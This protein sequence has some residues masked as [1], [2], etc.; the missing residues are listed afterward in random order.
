MF[1][2]IE[3]IEVAVRARMVQVYSEATGNSHWFSDYRLYKDLIRS[4][5]NGQT[6]SVFSRLMRE[7]ADEVARSNEDFIKH[8]AHK[9]SHP[10][11][12][13]AWMT[14]E[15]LS[16]GTLSKLYQLLKKSPEKKAI[17]KG[18]GLN[19]D[20]VMANWLH[21]IAVWRNCCAHHSR[22]WN[23]RSIINL[24]FPTNTDNPFIDR[25]TFHKAHANKLFVVLCCIKY[26]SNIISPK[27]DFKDN[28]LT[29][30]EK[31]G[32]L[33]NLQE[34]GFPADW[35]QFELWR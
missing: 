12:P 4:D 32:N 30:I 9:Y 31:G 21:A 10:A 1:N 15:V 23:R 7:V 34:M 25:N 14:L 16:L 29:I 11:M 19:D 6:Q 5:N 20:Q 2:A 28:I 33:L 26:I 27:S 35:E 18:F 13:P 22:V 8:Y 24:Q 17:A 3:K